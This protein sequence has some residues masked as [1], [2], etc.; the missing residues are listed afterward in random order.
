ML[1]PW[2]GGEGEWLALAIEADSP[3][4]MLGLAAFNIQD[5]IA[6]TGEIGYRLHPDHQGK[7]LCLE[8]MRCVVEYLF[9]IAQFHKLTG[10]CTADNL[11]SAR[12][13]EKL[14]MQREGCLRQHSMLAGVWH[15]ELVYGLLRTDIRV[16]G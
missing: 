9:E 7:G 1:Q 5:W 3:P 15:D 8:A 14:G 16:L 2:G 11:P 10:R 6:R 13:L 12:L 4:K